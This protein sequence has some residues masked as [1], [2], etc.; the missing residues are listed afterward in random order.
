VTPIPG[1]T[2]VSSIG[3]SLKEVTVK[4]PYLLTKHK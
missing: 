1:N 4:T 3:I 2:T